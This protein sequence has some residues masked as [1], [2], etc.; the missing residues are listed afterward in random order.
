VGRIAP[1]ELEIL[2]SSHASF[3]T[4]WATGTTLRDPSGVSKSSFYRSVKALVDRGFLDA[5]IK[6][7]GEIVAR[8]AAAFAP[9]RTGRLADSYRSSVR[10]TSAIVRNR[11][12]YGDLIEL[13]FH[14]GGGE[15]LVPGRTPI[16]RAV[17]RQEDVLVEQIARGFDKIARDRGFR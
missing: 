7:A 12:P 6:N 1:A 16:G 9:R 17:Q 13:G 15:T 8:E 11:V 2:S 10:G 4:N 5:V 14:P 3:G